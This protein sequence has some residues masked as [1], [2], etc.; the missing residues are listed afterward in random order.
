M[1][2]EFG[3]GAEK[4]HEIKEKI[5]SAAYHKAGTTLANHK[6]KRHSK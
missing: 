4:V 1:K 5:A 3:E 6:A 2:V